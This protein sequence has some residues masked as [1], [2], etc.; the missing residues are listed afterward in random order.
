M[1]E[2]KDHFYKKAKKEGLASR[3]A[4]KILEIEK[5]FK[6]W[7]KGS[8]ILDLGS[9]PG[10]W[11]QILSQE[12]GPSGFI[13]GVD[14]SPLKIAPPKNVDFIQKD[15]SDPELTFHQKFDCILSD[16][17][18]DL[19]G[20]RFRD[21]YRSYELAMRVWELAKLFLE[22]KGN[23]V[24]KIFPGEENNSL[25]KEIQKRFQKFQIFVPK[26]TRQASSEIYW[27][28]LGFEK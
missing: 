8:S 27:I 11:L 16:L 15:V 18:P 28:G 17:S 4:Y 2:R 14:R 23:L 5:K 9:A 25:Q 20:I 19:S 12:V 21:T 6:I 22:K 10:G 13:T 24:V 1:Y 26:A 3:A 7:K